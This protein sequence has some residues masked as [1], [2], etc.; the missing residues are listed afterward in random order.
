MELSLLR[1]TP[2][3]WVSVFHGVA[4]GVALGVWWAMPPFGPNWGFKEIAEAVT[5]LFVV[6]RVARYFITGSP[7][8]G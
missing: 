1:A 3:P 5:V 6:I 2:Q 8:V 4:C 7:L